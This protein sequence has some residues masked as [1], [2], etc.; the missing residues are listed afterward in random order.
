LGVALI[1][2]LLTRF[3]ALN[4]WPTQ[5][6]GFTCLGVAC[7]LLLLA[8]VASDLAP[9]PSRALAFLRSRL[10]ISV[11]RYSYG[12]Y[13][14]HMFFVIFAGAWLTRYVTPFGDA[15][16][17]AWSLFVIVLSYVAGFLSY[18]LYEKHFLRLGRYFAPAAR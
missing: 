11:G 18:H 4:T 2:A 9:R 17:L 1:G 8:A 16:L 15:R 12:M 10:L 7:T 13:V 6:L 14:F 5:T 3:Y